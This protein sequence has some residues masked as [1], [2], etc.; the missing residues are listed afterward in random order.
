MRRLAGLTLILALFFC[1][2]CRTSK[3]PPPTA[4]AVLT[5]MQS[6]MTRTAQP[7]PDGL[8]YS[9]QAATDAPQYL[10]ET[11][12]T[13][14]YGRAAEGLL[15]A[16]NASDGIPSVGD[17]ALFLSVAIYPCELAVFRCSDT[18]AVPT[19]VSLCRGRLDTVA[20]GFAGTEWESAAQGV[21]VT[22]GCF[23][24]LVVSEDPLTVAEGALA[25]LEKMR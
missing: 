1:S 5:A 12:F 24:L 3:S 7:L 20:R 14:L 21:V 10:T 6:V 25:A 15:A 16:E 8:I 22:E 11:F 19:V 9:R 23:V 17:A 4:E 18:D 2:S 13:A